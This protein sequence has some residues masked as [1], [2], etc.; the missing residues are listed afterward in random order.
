LAIDATYDFCLFNLCLGFCGKDLSFFYLSAYFLQ[1]I[2]QIWL[3]PNSAAYWASVAFFLGLISYAG[4]TFYS[5][6]VSII[7]AAKT[8]I[9]SSFSKES[10][11][12]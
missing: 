8:I 11:F 12:S 3:A 5:I 1:F 10:A 7:N 9:S 2:F 4:M 6:R